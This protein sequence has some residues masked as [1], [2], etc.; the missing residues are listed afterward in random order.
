MADAFPITTRLPSG[1]PAA[2]QPTA[3]MGDFSQLL[4]A[5]SAFIEAERD[6]E[7][8]DIWELATD[9]WLREAEE[10][11]AGT[12]TISSRRSGR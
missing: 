8:F 9:H 12:W 4:I 7:H 11:C 3:V 1:S 5:L 6:L 2:L 10:I